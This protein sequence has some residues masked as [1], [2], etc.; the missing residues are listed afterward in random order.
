MDF[1][2]L[3]FHQ[4]G[5]KR[6]DAQ[7]VQRGGAV[8]QNRMVFD[9]LFEDVPNHRVLLLDEFL[10]LLNGGAMAALLEA[11]IDEGLEQLERHFLRQTALVEA[12]I[13]TD[14]DYGTA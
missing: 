2:G 5:L 4:H 1:D 9:D 11:M 8:E 3:A 7:T 14:H 13:G 12:K 10:G 6:L